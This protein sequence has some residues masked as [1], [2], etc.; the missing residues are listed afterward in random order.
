MRVHVNG[1]LPLIK[2]SVVEFPN[3]DEVTTTLV[4]ERLD[5]H[6]TRCLRLDHE[7]KE[8]LVARAETKA[9]MASQEGVKGNSKNHSGQDSGSVREQ[10]DNAPFLFSASG[11]NDSKIRG[12]K[13]NYNAPVQSS[14]S[15]HRKDSDR[16]PT[17]DNRAATQGGYERYSRIPL[18]PTTHRHLPPPPGRSYYREVQKP[19]PET[20]DTGSSASKNLYVEPKRGLPGN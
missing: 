13:Q 2:E 5:K 9:L 7:L 10:K 15:T 3:G 16:R 17:K 12:R 14:A 6:C 18:E 11:H 1:L 20:K 4:Y 19:V 8:C